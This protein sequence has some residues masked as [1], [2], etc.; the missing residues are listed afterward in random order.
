MSL[1]LLHFLPLSLLSISNHD[2][3]NRKLLTQSRTAGCWC[4]NKGDLIIISSPTRGQPR[5]GRTSE[6]VANQKVLQRLSRWAWDQT[7]SDWWIVVVSTCLLTAKTW[8]CCCCCYFGWM[9]LARVC[10]IS[11]FNVHKSVARFLAT[12]RQTMCSSLKVQ[13]KLWKVKERNVCFALL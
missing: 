8:C 7:S 1:D 11:V 6:N 4:L 5:C 9:A 13:N 10:S 2:E 3:L 12:R